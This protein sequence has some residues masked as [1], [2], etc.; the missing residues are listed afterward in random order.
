MQKQ[1][2]KKQRSKEAQ[3]IQPTERISESLLFD[4]A[5]SMNVQA[6]CAAFALLTLR[7][8]SVLVTSD[9]S[10]PSFFQL[11]V[12]SAVQAPAHTRLTCSPSQTNREG[13]CCTCTCFCTHS[14][15]LVLYY[16]GVFHREHN[17]MEEVYNK[18]NQILSIRNMILPQRSSGS[19]QIRVKEDWSQTYSVPP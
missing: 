11:Y 6:Q 4:P 14:I 17:S 10:A 1:E 8:T 3:S 16:Y 15:I 2:A 12:P 18:G 19:L 9:S 13:T 7:K 5:E